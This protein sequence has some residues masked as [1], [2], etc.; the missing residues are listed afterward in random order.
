M[1][2][3]KTYNKDKIISIIRNRLENSTDSGVLSEQK[4][5]D[6][7]VAA[8]LGELQVAQLELEMQND[9]LSISAQMLETERSRF[10]SFFNL[11]PVGYFI[12][13]EFG[14]VIEANQVGTDLLRVSKRDI[15]NKGFQIFIAPVDWENFY[16]FLHKM[17]QND[18]KQSL[19]IRV[20]QTDGQ[21]IFTLMEGIAVSNAFTE[22]IQYYITVIDISESR[23]A[24]QKLLNTTQRLE[25]TLKASATGT[26]TM[27]LG[28]NKVFFDD[29]SCSMLE[30]NPAEFDGSIQGFL[31]I[32]HP[33]DQAFVKHSLLNAMNSFKEVD[34]EFRLINKDGHIKIFS[35]KGHEVQSKVAPNYFA[36]IIMDI[37]ERKRLEQR[38]REVQNEKQKL[39]LSATFNA[40][41][42]ERYKISSALHDSVCQILYGIRLNIQNIQLSHDLQGGFRNINQLL[43]QAIR[44]T[45]EL[46]YE[47][48]PSI[49]RDFGFKA[50]VK[51]MA[52][53]LST[54]N[55]RIKT[56][57][58]NTADLLQTETQ[59]YVFRMV[60]E[61]INN[62][63]KHANATEA[64]ICVYAD[65][66][67]ITL[68]IRDNGIGFGI[69]IEHAMAKGSG[70]RG[71]KNRVFLLNGTIDMKSSGEGTEITIRFQIDL[72]S[73]EIT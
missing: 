29:F 43:D 49:L 30:I 12:L 56:N 14:Q 23:T 34:L 57:L 59:L 35:A 42:K 46:S 70:L 55:F 33:D 10:V 9:E 47:L 5:A 50:G 39:I 26:W 65:D 38:A 22:N 37:T 20:A 4:T 51:E 21:E 48:T 1:N 45:R 61:L 44:E 67:W 6:K 69:E 40:Q 53:R 7:Q 64:E 41:E 71:I 16:S 27:E 18:H 62:C 68:I 58:K 2:K 3:K 60:Q 13:D 25:M 32:L 63:I 54:S 36:G 31:E 15:L 73:K 28:N 17:Q 52:Q 66:K 72:E 19:E 8:L 24:Q 11:A